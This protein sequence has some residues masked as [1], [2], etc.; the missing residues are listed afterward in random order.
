[1]SVISQ[2]SWEGKTFLEKKRK[3]KKGNYFKQKLQDFLEQKEMNLLQTVLSKINVKISIPRHIFT[4]FQN[5]R[6][7]NR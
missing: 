4:Q 3:W 1:M 5:N 7:K 6:E 2:Y